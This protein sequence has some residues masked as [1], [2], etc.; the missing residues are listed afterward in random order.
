MKNIIIISFA[1]LFSIA[2]GATAQQTSMGN[3]NQTAN[4]AVV[5]SPNN[6][7]VVSSH[8]TS[9]EK[10]VPAPPSSKSSTE[11]PMARPIDV[12]QMNADIEKAEAEYKKN[13]KAKEALARAYFIRATA[14]TD[15]AQY[16]SALGDYRKGLKLDPNDEDAKKMHDQI[17]T[18][19]QQI[20][21]EP[22]KEGEE[23][24]PLP[25]N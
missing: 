13:P 2:C 1:S 25:V 24:K 5:H 19:F 14:L 21:R 16:R 9:G 4:N 23:P 20:G 17:I 15:A 6:S 7:A 8:S 22:P 3:Q 18:I 11:S 12:A 10:S